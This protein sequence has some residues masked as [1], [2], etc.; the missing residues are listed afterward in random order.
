MHCK[1]SI[2]I[3][4]V[5][6]TD[7]FPLIICYDC[8]SLFVLFIMLFGCINVYHSGAFCISFAYFVCLLSK[9]LSLLLVLFEFSESL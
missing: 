1:I 9:V 6:N 8:R 3:Q 5:F 7:M 4:D 2:K